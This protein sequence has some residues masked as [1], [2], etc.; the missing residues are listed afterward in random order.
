MS[1]P[2]P[3]VT[4]GTRDASPEVLLAA[5][6][7]EV[8]LLRDALH[9][10]AVRD[11][12]GAS[13][14]GGAAGTA[15]SDVLEGKYLA[16]IKANKDLTV[17]LASTQRHLATAQAALQTERDKS[18][19][20]VAAMTTSAVG[21]HGEGSPPPSRTVG[22]AGKSGGDGGASS[23]AATAAAARVYDEL[24][25]KELAMAAVQRD[26]A[27]LRALLQREVGLR[28]DAGEVD[29][30]LQR[31]TSTGGA[32]ADTAGGGWRGRAEEV[33]L[34]KGKLKDAQRELR[35]VTAAATAAAAAQGGGGGDGDSVDERA[36][37]LAL[38]ASVRAFLGVKDASSKPA[39]TRSSATSVAT[40][41][42][43]QARRP[44]RDVDDAA[45]DRLTSM[46]Q[47]R[48]A[49]QHRHAADLAQQQQL[50]A[51]ERAKTAALQAR[52]T[53]L[54]SELD[55]LRGHVDTI[56]DKSRTDDELV[57][58]YKLEL[59]RAHEDV[60]R[61]QR[62]AAEAQAEVAATAGRGGDGGAGAALTVRGMRNGAN[63]AVAAAARVA[64]Y[65]STA[66]GGADSGRGAGGA[67]SP[68]PPSFSAA[69]YAWVCSAC[70]EAPVD[71]VAHAAAAASAP[72]TPTTA[73]AAQ[74]AAVLRR[75]FHHVVAAERHAAASLAAASPITASPNDAESVLAKENAVLKKRLRNVTEMLETE[76]QVQRAL[77]ASAD[78]SVRG[79]S[80]T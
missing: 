17:Q 50:M 52:V 27:A 76:L 16:L 69:L 75:A 37:A 43:T 10:F 58:A 66:A 51:E 80:T 71:E 45:R 73:A 19:R 8:K 77:W 30:L 67:P 64:H 46:Q 47:Q 78:G 2:S 28:D 60:R 54:K 22:P 4:Q 15:F 65:R 79:E 55:T 32:A 49:Q 13:R 57:E 7:A 5:S 48:A 61:W 6:K 26:N 40:T 39:E 72:I 74:L 68:P 18:Q 70:D 35:R 31:T 3:A 41:A 25:Q 9:E 14:G 59:H 38:P 34:L 56:L 62:A 11:G 33:V 24:H 20:L 63:D 29:A 36:D 1:G 53:T 23:S 21:T 44:P 12:G 42:A